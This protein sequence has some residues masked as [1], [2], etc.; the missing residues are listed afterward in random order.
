MLV[1]VFISL[2]NMVATR[3]CLEIRLK[4]EVKTRIVLVFWFWTSRFC[5]TWSG[6]QE[7]NIICIYIYCIHTTIIHSRLG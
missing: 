2:Y 7:Y 1:F 6:A 5:V 3:N 4:M